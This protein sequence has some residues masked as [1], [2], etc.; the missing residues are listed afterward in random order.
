MKRFYL[1]VTL[2]GLLLLFCVM[3]GVSLASSGV[4][5]ISG[6]MGAAGAA[7]K[8]T[9]GGVKAAVAGNAGAGRTQAGAGG[10][11]RTAGENAGSESKGA[12]KTAS[13]G[14]GKGTAKGTAGGSGKGLSTGKSGATAGNGGAQGAG[15][16]EHGLSPAGKD[17]ALNQVGNKF[18]DLLQIMAYHGI[19]AF[20]GLFDSVLGK[21]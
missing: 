6:P 1:K 4:E 9:D 2:F 18:G 13:A 11:A 5:R 15:A 14:S 20:I 3:F 10:E 12:V 19:R 21:G 17:A 7:A 8:E 16:Q